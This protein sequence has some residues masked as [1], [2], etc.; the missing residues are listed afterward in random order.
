MPTDTSD[1]QITLP[2]GA[3]AANNPTAFTNFVA[4]VEQRLLRRYTNEA[5][6]TARMLTVTENDVSTL[7][8]E[9]RV[10]IYNGANHISLYERA[11]FGVG[12][13]AST[14]T[15]T[16]SST[17]LQNI[18]GMVVAMPTSGV[19]SFRGVF[20]YNV[21]TAADIKFAFT[22]PAGASIR[23]GGLGAA[24]SGGAIGDGNWF[25]TTGGG[26]SLSFGGG[27]I[28]TVMMCIVEGEYFTGG[29]AGNLQ[30]QAAQNTSEA[31]VSTV[32]D[33]SRF[34]VWRHS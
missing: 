3:D 2:V 13:L 28:G 31:S 30:L 1:Q 34:E 25:T 20:Y 5:D 9:N 26:N 21:T 4:D 19:F 11:V 22:I 16:A 17:T 23:W 18:T 14:Q 15:L 6:R 10:D 29:I 24:T 7:A 12:R 32:V 8:T 27:G 33:G